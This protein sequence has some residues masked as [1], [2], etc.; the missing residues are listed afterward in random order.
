MQPGPR[1]NKKTYKA[2]LR[3]K[4]QVIQNAPQDD[5]ETLYHDI[6]QWEQ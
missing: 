6:D 2:L 3:R 5:E 1:V 4:M